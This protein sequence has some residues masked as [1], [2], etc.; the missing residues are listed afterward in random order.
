MLQ[1]NPNLKQIARRLRR[2]TTE[3]ER[4]LWSHLRRRQL[5]D[6][7]FYRQK[8][9]GNYIVDFYAPK[10]RLVIEVDGSQHLEEIHS[11]NDVYRDECLA[12]QGLKV[13]RF[14]N[15]Q[16]LKECDAV[17]EVIHGTLE[18]RLNKTPSRGLPLSQRGIRGISP[19][20]LKT[21]IKLNQTPEPKINH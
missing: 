19:A 17:L 18:E 6:V 7:Q 4:M 3:S 14:N 11:E 9:I 10:A 2:E 21:N 12:S 15:L 1:Y 20:A 5:L 13:L 8:P 16:V